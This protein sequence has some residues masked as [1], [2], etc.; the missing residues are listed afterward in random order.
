MSVILIVEDDL[1]AQKTLELMITSYTE[2][3]TL[4][5]TNSKEAFLLVPQADLILLDAMFA[6]KDGIQIFQELR[7]KTKTRDI[8]VI[9]ITDH[10]DAITEK[11]PPQTLGSIDY[12]VKP[13]KKDQ[14][15]NRL[16]VLLGV[17]ES[18]SR[19]QK[20]QLSEA[21]QLVLLLAA[22]EQSADGVTVTDPQG[23]GM[24]INK[25][26]GTM[27]GY[28]IDEL[29]LLKLDAIYPPASAEKIKNKIIPSLEKKDHWE[30]ELEGR[31]K[32]G[33]IFPILLSLSVVK[34]N[35]G[36]F[37][38]IMGITKDITT[39]KKAFSDLEEAQAALVH[40]E[41]LKAVGEMVAGIAH[42][43]N[44]L[45]ASILG[46][47]QLLL[48]KVKDP[49]Y[50]K[51]LRVIE[52]N[53]LAAA[54]A[55]RRLQTFTIAGISSTTSLVDVSNLL[56]EVL[57]TTRPRWRDVSQ[58]HGLVIEV[59]SDLKETPPIK[60]NEGELKRALINI[61]FNAIESLP[62]GGKIHIRNWAEGSSIYIEIADTGIGISPEIKERV[63][64]PY[65]TTK[66][67]TKSGLGLSV[68]YGTIKK[69]NG[70]IEIQSKPG[71]GTTVTIKL[72][73]AEPEGEKSPAKKV[74][75][76]AD[77]SRRILAINDNSDILTV[78]DEVLSSANYDVT[79]RK[80]VER[81]F[82]EA[83]TGDFDLV[84]T[85]LKLAEIDGLELA[86]KVKKASP[87]TKLVLLT[88]IGEMPDQKKLTEAGVEAVWHKPFRLEELLEQVRKILP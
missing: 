67:P 60:G 40:S 74:E 13:I 68:A 61:V 38:G 82:K 35:A 7:D 77:T 32:S 88:D 22:L 31:K 29:F 19:F 41:R 28:T 83:S 66:R 49:T 36:K 25:A 47:T 76:P 42:D 34:D 53:V 12:V 73:L 59:E 17:S 71:Q 26:M 78:L 33:E 52:R 9:F 20:T 63:F 69:Y 15:L 62:Q 50:L 44:N 58:K 57:K 14:L 3:Q 24:M 56:T 65:F 84:I 45:L 5:A 6:G 2:H 75:N 18:R 23:R 30:G 51:R 37:L 11:L 79:V 16:Q 72:P 8:P 10:P 46:N 87:R 21:D 64:E 80:A 43:F 48:Q 4:V 70:E 39:L 27:Y 1:E 55:V 54:D 85:D 86:R 81:G